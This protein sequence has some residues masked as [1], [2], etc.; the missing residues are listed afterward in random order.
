MD[1][2]RLN[3]TLRRRTAKLAATERRL[4][5]DIAQ[6]KHSAASLKRKEPQRAQMLKESLQLQAGLRTL[7]RRVLAVQEEERTTLSRELQDEVVQTLVGIHVRLLLLK[8]ESWSSTQDLQN[9][10]TGTQHL[11][12][13]SARLIRRVAHKLK[14]Q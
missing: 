14:V 4:R 2:T 5:R 7:A 11:V 3:E 13:K 1:L 6:R 10:I 12:S 8:K 9:E